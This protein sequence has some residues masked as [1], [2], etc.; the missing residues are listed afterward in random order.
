[1]DPLGNSACQQEGIAVSSAATS[2]PKET[3]TNKRTAITNTETHSV[4]TTITSGGDIGF[5]TDSISI[6]LTASVA[7]TV[8][9]STAEG[10]TVICPSGLWWCSVLITPGMMQVNGHM[11]ELGASDSCHPYPAYTDG[12]WQA[13]MPRTDQAGNGVW[14]AEVCACQNKPY[15]L[16]AGAPKPCI[17]DCA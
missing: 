9:D 13:V 4:G 11:Q 2:T 8:T 10:G 3:N 15:G 16:D 5:S 7:H 6:G 1:M 14:S 17:E 12:N